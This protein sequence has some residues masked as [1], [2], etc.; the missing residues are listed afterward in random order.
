[1]T[2]TEA[3]KLHILIILDPISGCNDIRRQLLSR[4]H[5]DTLINGMNVRKECVRDLTA[6][7]ELLQN[8]IKSGTAPATVNSY[9]SWILH[10]YKRENR[11]KVA[12]HCLIL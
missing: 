7:N 1:M 6:T 2:R 5:F 12:V 3:P 9:V 11:K 10:N 8:F 4:E